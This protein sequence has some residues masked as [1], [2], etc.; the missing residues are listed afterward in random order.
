MKKFYALFLLLNSFTFYFSQTVIELKHIS[1]NTTVVTNNQ[2]F[3]ET[4]TAFSTK[5]TN[6][7][8]KNVAS[9]TKGFYIQKYDNVINTVNASDK[10]EANFCTGTV[11]YPP[12][13]MSATLSLTAGESIDFIADLLEA[14]V[15]GQ[16]NVSYEISDL[17]NPT[18]MLTISFSYNAPTGIHEISIVRSFSNLYPNPANNLVN[19]NLNLAKD[20]Q[21]AS[22]KIF[23]AIG[24][25]VFDRTL[26][27]TKGMNPV[28]A[29]VSSLESGIYFTQLTVDNYKLP[30]KKLTI[31][32]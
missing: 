28:Q 27:L 14:S 26:E 16:S 29:D 15:I 7:K 6:F 20:V 19:F 32:K 1:T 23:N 22:L 24:E 10:A 18:D 12:T 11:C 21:S 31:T 30:A 5:A 8:L 9:S 17:N 25:V 13:T 2:V 4:T 3:N